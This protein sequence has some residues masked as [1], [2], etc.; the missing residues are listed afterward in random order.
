MLAEIELGNSFIS[1]IT[2]L[3]TNNQRYSNMFSKDHN[4]GLLLLITSFE[5]V[6]EKIIRMMLRASNSNKISELKCSIGSRL[7]NRPITFKLIIL[8]FPFWKICTFAQQNQ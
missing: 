7:P 6:K 3:C 1:K 8:F 4:K 2:I 5:E